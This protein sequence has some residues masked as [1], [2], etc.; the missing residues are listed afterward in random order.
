[1]LVRPPGRAEMVIAETAKHGDSQAQPSY[2]SARSSTEEQP[3]VDS[4]APS[5][6]TSS[7]IFTGL[8]NLIEVVLEVSSP[9]LA[10]ERIIS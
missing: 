6:L 5:G 7:I 10:E 8:R 3:I 4:R 9:K 2:L 1:M